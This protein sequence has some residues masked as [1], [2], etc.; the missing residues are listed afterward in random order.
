MQHRR[1][2]HRKNGNAISDAVFYHS[3]DSAFWNEKID[4]MP[5]LQSAV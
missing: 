2:V 1:A 5:E 3:D 4:R